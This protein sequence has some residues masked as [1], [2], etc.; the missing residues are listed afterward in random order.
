[1]G[2]PIVT[3]DCYNLC[4]QVLDLFSP[5]YSYIYMMLYNCGNRFLVV[6]MIFKSQSPLTL[7]VWLSV[8]SLYSKS[9]HTLPSVSDQLFPDLALISSALNEVD[10]CSF[11]I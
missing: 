5:V 3:K 4:H 7:M 6:L 11:Y 8:T 1:M 2:D 10:C 9:H